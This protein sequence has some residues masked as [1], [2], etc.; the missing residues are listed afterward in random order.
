MNNKSQVRCGTGGSCT[1]LLKRTEQKTK[2]GRYD[3]AWVRP[4]SML[5]AHSFDLFI[6]RVM[7]LCENPT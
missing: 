3:G 7:P 4:L 1:L 5:R 2:K 6:I